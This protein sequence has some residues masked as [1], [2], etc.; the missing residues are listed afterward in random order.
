M[1]SSLKVPPQHFNKVELW[2]LK[3]KPK[4]QCDWLCQLFMTHFQSG[5]L[6]DAKILWYTSWCTQWLQGAQILSSLLMCCVW[7]FGFLQPNI[8][9]VQRTSVQM[10]FCKPQ[11]CTH[12][13]GIPDKQAKCIQSFF[14]NYSVMNFYEL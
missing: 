3:I 13:L 2:I 6:F 10:Q 5:S 12:S 14:F 1:H 11:L 7:F 8:S 4:N 9:A